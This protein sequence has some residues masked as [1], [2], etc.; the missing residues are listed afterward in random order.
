[1]VAEG[2]GR[3]RPFPGVSTRSNSR[4]LSRR[5][6]VGTDGRLRPSVISKRRAATTSDQVR[7][8]V[9][10]GRTDGQETVRP[11]QYGVTIHGRV[12]QRER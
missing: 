7:S 10:R 2:K 1:M 5:L 8:S 9:R 12:R 4:R 3:T 11:R 6:L